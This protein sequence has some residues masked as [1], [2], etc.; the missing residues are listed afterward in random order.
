MIYIFYQPPLQ[1]VNIMR[2]IP[3][4]LQASDT[5]LKEQQFVYSNIHR[6]T[7][8]TC[9]AAISSAEPIQLLTI[10][11]GKNTEKMISVQTAL[12]KQFPPVKLVLSSLCTSQQRENKQQTV[13]AR[14]LVIPKYF[15]LKVMISD[16][17]SMSSYL[18][19]ELKPS[20]HCVFSN[21]KTPDRD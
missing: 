7:E 4:I 1:L 13:L 15:W 8:I 17:E 11:R 6:S 2:L 5:F 10:T 18:K 16:N 21:T 14:F 20:C 19:I 12:A 9:T 3:H